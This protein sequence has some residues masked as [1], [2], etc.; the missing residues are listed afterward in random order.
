M[1]QIHW[2]KNN[3]FVHYGGPGLEM[4]H[5]LGYVSKIDDQHSPQQTLFQF[6]N[7]ARRKSTDALVEQIAPIVYRDPDGILFAELVR[8]DLQPL[9]CIIANISRCD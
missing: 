1:T 7:D 4:F 8:D 3:Y 9:P 5:V 6:E 2:D